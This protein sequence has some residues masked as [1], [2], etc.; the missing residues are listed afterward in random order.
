MLVAA[1]GQDAI[2]IIGQGLFYS[3]VVLVC[4]WYGVKLGDRFGRDSL[5]SLAVGILSLGAAASI[6]KIL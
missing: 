6:L 5:N 1:M 3:P 4:S 2:A